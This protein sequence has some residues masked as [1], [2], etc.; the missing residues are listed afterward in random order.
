MANPADRIAAPVIVRCYSRSGRWGLVAAAGLMTLVT[1]LLIPGFWSMGLTTLSVV[2][3]LILVGLIVFSVIIAA[4]SMFNRVRIHVMGGDVVIESGPVPW[5]S[6]R[7]IAAA[8]IEQA[9]AAGQAPLAE[10]RRAV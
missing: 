9:G 10:P 8:S 3:S 2:F 6:S 7:V 4:A 5:N 1:A